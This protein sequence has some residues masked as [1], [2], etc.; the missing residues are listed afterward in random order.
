MS[1]TQLEQ[2]GQRNWIPS[3][4]TRLQVTLI[5]LSHENLVAVTVLLFY[6]VVFLRLFQA[7]YIS[8]ITYQPVSID[9]S[10]W[11]GYLGFLT[12]LH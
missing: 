11:V 5:F 2:E 8:S 1:L 12:A 6:Y 10:A 4:T 7:Q 3:E 9:S